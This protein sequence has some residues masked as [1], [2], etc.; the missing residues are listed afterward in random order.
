MNSLSLLL[1]VSEVLP[2]LSILLLIIG[3]LSFAVASISSLRLMEGGEFEGE[4]VKK[5]C[6][7]L[8]MSLLIVFTSLLIPSKDTILLIAASEI[9]EEGIN[10]EYGQEILSGLKE[11]LDAQLEA[12]K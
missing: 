8:L 5:S 3:L 7:Q 10:S 11:V 9:G 2:N 1:Y 4:S 12:L 6:K